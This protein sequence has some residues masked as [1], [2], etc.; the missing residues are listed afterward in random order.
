MPGRLGAKKEPILERNQ[1][2]AQ[3]Q[4]HCHVAQACSFYIAPLTKIKNHD[5]KH[6]HKDHVYK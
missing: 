1:N 6:N 3:F 5:A 2:T 4:V